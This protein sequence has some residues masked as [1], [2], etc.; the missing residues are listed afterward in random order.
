MGEREGCPR[1]EEEEVQT[2]F[3]VVQKVFVYSN[4]GQKYRVFRR[5]EAKM[6]CW[7]SLQKMHVNVDV[8]DLGCAVK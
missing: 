8:R 5:W 2:S 6:S 4:S 7:K 3:S 1:I